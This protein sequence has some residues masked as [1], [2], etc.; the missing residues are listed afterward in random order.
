MS[1]VMT[2]CCHG[3]LYEDCVFGCKL[4]GYTRTGRNHYINTERYDCYSDG[5]YWNLWCIADT[6]GGMTGIAGSKGYDLYHK[7]KKIKHG[8]TVK[9]LKQFVKDQQS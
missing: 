7:G 3:T 8:K 6:C 1:D 5:P 2:K 4:W 9:E